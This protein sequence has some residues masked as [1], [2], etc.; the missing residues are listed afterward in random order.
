MADVAQTTV[1]C[2]TAFYRAVGSFSKDINVAIRIA[3]LGL[4]VM[5]LFAGYMQSF[6]SMKSWVYKWI[7]YATP[8]SY[9][10]E[11]IMVNQFHG[12]QLECSPSNLVP[13]IPGASIMNKGMLSVYG[14][15]CR[16]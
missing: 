10:Q 6:K 16:C 12:M 3:F 14:T 5:G 2:L 7:F 11:A 4:N 1:I 9:A 15:V 8:L 13:G